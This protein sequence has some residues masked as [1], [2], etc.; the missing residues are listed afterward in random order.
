MYFN[1]QLV[2]EMNSALPPRGKPMNSST[3]T[4]PVVLLCQ[5]PPRAAHTIHARLLELDKAAERHAPPSIEPEDVDRLELMTKDSSN[6]AL[7]LTN[8]NVA[9]GEGS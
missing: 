2:C 7:E 5:C 4:L 6:N 3:A 1:I 8:R 9:T